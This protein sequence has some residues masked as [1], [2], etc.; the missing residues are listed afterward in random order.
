M[1]TIG[2]VDHLMQFDANARS[3]MEHH[4]HPESHPFEWISP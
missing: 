4:F 1:S 3:V 2:V